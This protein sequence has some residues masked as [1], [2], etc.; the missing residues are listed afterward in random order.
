MD[1]SLRCANCGE[2]GHTA[3]D[4]PAPKCE[5][6][7]QVCGR[8]GHGV[9]GTCIFEFCSRC[10]QQ[11]HATHNCS[12]KSVERQEFCLHCGAL[13]HVECAQVGLIKAITTEC[14]CIACQQ[15][16]HALCMGDG[17]SPDWS[18]PFP[19]FNE[20][21]NRKAMVI[22]AEPEP[23]LICLNCSSRQHTFEE[24]PG[25]SM[26]TRVERFFSDSSNLYCFQCRGTGHFARNCPE[27]EQRTP[28]R[29]QNSWSENKNYNRE[30][31][32]ARRRS[33]FENDNNQD[34]EREQRTPARRQS[35]FGNNN[36]DRGREQQ[37][38]ASKHSWF[39]GENED[40]FPR[41]RDPRPPSR[42]HDWFEANANE[43]SS[44][45]S[46]SSSS[47]SASH[48]T[49]SARQI[50]RQHLQPQSRQ[51]SRAQFKNLKNQQRQ[52]K[53]QKKAEL[54]QQ[55]LQRKYEA[56]ARKQEEK[57]RKQEEAFLPKSKIKQNGV[58]GKLKKTHAKSAPLPDFIPL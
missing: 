38:S 25:E 44:A 48:S 6:T 30:R 46:P 42:R 24:C 19:L 8:P 11:G 33:W 28:A 12:N 41:G 56:R 54:K 17:S 4:C 21:Y 26:D 15:V 31:I 10:F 39:E 2:T 13:G 14:T 43:N 49:M 35:R 36:Q 51:A 58:S 9:S 18:A 5:K 40:S 1:A 32:P 55:S 50:R 23:S 16:G 29:T 45:P 7:C 27:R 34:R 53:Q 22:L 57:A 47:S 52:E 37:T 20:K 3:A